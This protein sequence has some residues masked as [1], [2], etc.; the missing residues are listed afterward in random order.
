MT[1]NAAYLDLYQRTAGNLRRVL[2]AL[3]LKRRPREVNPTLDQYLGREDT[4]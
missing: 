4:R 2:E 3:G 1:S